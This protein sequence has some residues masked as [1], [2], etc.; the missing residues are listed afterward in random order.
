MIIHYYL[1]YN[2]A[3]KE[4]ELCINTDK[5][6]YININQNNNMKMKSICGSVINQVEDL[7]I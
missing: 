4:I 2:S 3:A 6:E 5:T 1:K 7:N